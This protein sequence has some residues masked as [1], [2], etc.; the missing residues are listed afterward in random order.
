MF[1]SAK[2]GTTTAPDVVP[3]ETAPDPGPWTTACAHYC[4][5]GTVEVPYTAMPTVPSPR[6]TQSPGGSAVSIS[7]HEL[8]HLANDVDDMHHEAMRNFAAEAA[9]LHLGA[10]RSFL[11]KAG[12]AGLSGTLLAAGGGVTTLSY[13]GGGTAAAQQGLTDTTLAGYAQGI[14]LAAVAVYTA[15]AEKLSGA[16]LEVATLFA[17][18]HQDHADAFA[19]LAG[20]DAQPKANPKLMKGIAPSLK[21]IAAGQ[22]SEA[23]TTQILDFGRVIENQVTYTYAGGLALLT[24]PSY[25]AVTATILPIEAQHATVISLA[26]GGNA[27]MLFPTGPFETAQLGDGTDPL[28]GFDPILLSIRPKP[29]S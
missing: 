17:S 28:S 22:P 11:K 27:D 19:A 29:A 25:A 16:V 13:L 5:T 2:M 20:D 9:E 26:L 4:E 14:E 6:S 18:H 1:P 12:L 23:L 3:E 10:R 15:V 24:D 8:R 7:D 21:L